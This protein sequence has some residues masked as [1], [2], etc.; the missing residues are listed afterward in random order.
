MIY[1]FPRMTKCTFHKFGTSGEV[2]KHDALCI[3]PLNIGSTSHCLRC[4]QFDWYYCFRFDP[5]VLSSVIFS[6]K[7]AH[8]KHWIRN[9]STSQSTCILYR[10]ISIL[11]I[12]MISTTFQE[13][14][15]QSMK[16]FTSSSGFGYCCSPVCLP[17][18]SH[19]EWVSFK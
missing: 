11:H 8:Q 16:K 7:M 19:T 1:I 5:K 12:S 14:L 18:Q 13:S 3:L 15:F 9:S 17:Q 10:V 2:E 4:V 6:S